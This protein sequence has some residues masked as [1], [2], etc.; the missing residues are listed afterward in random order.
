ME[1]F[2]VSIRC[3]TPVLLTM[4]LGILIRA[5]ARFP[6]ELYGQLSTLCFRFL[7]PFQLFY[8]IYS[9][10]MEGAF[11]PKLLLFLEAGVLIWFLVNYAF[12]CGVVPDRRTR[13]AY[14]QNSFRSN[15]A[16]VGVSL[17]QTMMGG[18]PGVA[19]MS[20][21]T[22][23][24]VPTYNVLA[25]ITLESCRGGKARPDE[26]VK[27]ILKN[28]LIRACLLGVVCLGLGI[29]LPQ[30]VDQA[31]KNIGSAGSV[32]TLVALGASLRLEGAR[33]NNRRIIF[34]NVHRLVLTPLVMLTAACLMGFRGDALAVILICAGTPTATTSYPMALA[35]DSDHEL[36]AQAVV[37]TSLFFCLSM[38]LWIF[39][40]KQMGLM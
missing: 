40:L 21:A 6:E 36:T 7:L 17:A 13:G 25:V 30:P 20:I 15:I 34:C 23:V 26:T 33:K 35:C 8:N 5:C 37:T 4:C 3:I 31:V 22:A 28:P 12:F 38:L 2:I 11:S 16:V 39:A 32:M 27:Q 10:K 29:R 14:I 18:G 1:N 9:A 19:A 24:L